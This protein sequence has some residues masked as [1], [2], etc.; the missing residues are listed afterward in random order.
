M[1]VVLITGLLNV[2]A[3]RAIAQ[4]SIDEDKLDTVKG[5]SWGGRGLSFSK[6]LNIKDTLVNA[7]LG[8]VVID[9]HGEPTG[10]LDNPLAGPDPGRFAIVSLWG[11]KIEGCFAQMIVQSAPVN[12]KANLKEL[13][14]QQIELGIGNQILKLTLNPN[15][16]VRGFSINYT[17]TRYKNNVKTKYSSTW[18][19]TNTIFAVNA[20]TANLLRNAPAKEVRVRLTFAD[21]DT[22]V[23]PIGEGTV[24][25]WQESYGFN[26]ACAAPN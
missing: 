7:P 14:P 3:L 9:R 8:K 12:G 10:L 20:D 19:M 6:V 17:Y 25:K 15:T 24:K 26:S 4:N 5:I 11:S 16:R 13:V 18:Y 2:V 21:G 1:A 22:K 23:F